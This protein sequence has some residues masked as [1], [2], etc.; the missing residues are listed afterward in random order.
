MQATRDGER[1]IRKA[2]SL[3]AARR[4]ANQMIRKHIR[5]CQYSVDSSMYRQIPA[6]PANSHV[7]MRS[8]TV[9][10]LTYINCVS[11]SLRFPPGC[12]LIATDVRSAMFEIATECRLDDFTAPLPADHS[13][14]A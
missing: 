6:L 12:R 8:Q 13:Q 1:A 3:D 7:A 14:P 4:G 11:P 2:L 5:N 9:W 10:G